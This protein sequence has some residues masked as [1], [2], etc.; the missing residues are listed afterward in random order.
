MLYEEVAKS[1]APKP[2]NLPAPLTHVFDGVLIE[3]QV[4]GDNAGQG[5]AHLP[6]RPR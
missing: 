3:R 1:S 5:S 4:F 6:V 2:S